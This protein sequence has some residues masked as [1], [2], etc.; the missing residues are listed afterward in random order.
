MLID[1]QFRAQ[2]AH[3]HQE[4]PEASFEILIWEG[5]P[6]GNLTT[7]V[8]ETGLKLI[9]VNVLPA[10][11]G[12]GFGTALLSEVIEQSKGR[13]ITLHVITTNRARAL[14]SRM[15]FQEEEILEPYVR[16]VRPSTP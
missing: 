1:M 14:Y 9:D 4:Y 3:Y 6:V 12:R 8:T 7:E 2:R 15:G 5:Q 13:P 10:Y 11:Q 16:M